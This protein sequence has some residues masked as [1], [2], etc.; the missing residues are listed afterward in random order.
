MITTTQYFGK[1]GS[2][3]TPTILKAADNL[4][5][6][7]NALIAHMVACGIEFKANPATNSLV[8]GHNYGGFRPQDCPEGAPKSAHKVGM[9]V[10]LYDPNGK[11]DAWLLANEKLLD[12]FGLWFEH[13]DDTKGWSHFSTRKPKSGKIFF[14]P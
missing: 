10:D 5:S 3:A 4:L 9:A 2:D 6:K 12:H 8:S 13:P 1:W 11:I 7:V 14:H